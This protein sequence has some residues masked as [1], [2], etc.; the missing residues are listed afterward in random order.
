[1]H[2]VYR[3]VSIVEYHGES[4]EIIGKAPSFPEGMKSAFS[5]MLLVF[6]GISAPA[7][8]SLAI[9]NDGRIVKISDY[10]VS[11]EDI[12]ITLPG[13]GGYTTSLLA[14]ERIVDDEVAAPPAEVKDLKPARKGLDLSYKT[15]RNASR[16][17]PYARLIDEEC[18][19]ANLDV[20]FVTALI[21]AESNFNPYAVSRK[22]ARGLMQLMPATAERLGVRR[23]F[24]PAANI[25]GGVR[26]LKSLCVRFSNA[27]ELVLAA[28][29]AG[30]DAVESYGGVPPYRETVNYVK[31]ILSWWSPAPAAPTV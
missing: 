29:N 20:G 7:G 19:K 25:R 22:G 17:T 9:F 24:D 6:C 28:Y 31:K 8:A 15:V 23:S 1:M 16:P 27:P 18:R 2:L 14:V 30:E 13:G 26:Y 12:E 10:R 11:G 3:G 4:M 5:L 21:R